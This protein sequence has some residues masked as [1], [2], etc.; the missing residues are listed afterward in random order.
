MKNLLI[1]IDH[2]GSVSSE[3]FNAS[4]LAAKFFVDSNPDYNVSILLFDTGITELS[5]D[6]VKCL[7]DGKFAPIWG[8]GSD[9]QPVLDKAKDYD[10]VLVCTD[11]HL[12]YDQK[13]LPKHIHVHIV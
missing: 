10:K 5:N 13:S 1:A 4:T 12:S 9:I 7:L 3:Q 2:S 8:G 6:D 11:G